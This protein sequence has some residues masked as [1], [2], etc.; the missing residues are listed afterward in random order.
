MTVSRAIILAAGQGFQLD[1]I[2]KV[3]LRHPTTGKTILQ[4]AIE[5]FNG[6]EITVVVGYK[7]IDIMQDY[8]Q[9]DYVINPDWAASSN[10]LSLGLALDDRP[11]Y[12][13][14]GDIFLS[15]DLIA[16]LDQSAPDLV[17]CEGRENRSLTAVH[18]VFDEA[19]VLEETYHGPVRDHKHPEA[20]GLFK[21]S[22]S[23]LLQRW[24]KQ[25]L[26]HSNLFVGETLPFDSAPIHR[27]D[28]GEHA[29]DEI[30]THVDYLN[31]LQRCR[32][33]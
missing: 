24:K 28:L 26:K 33:P 4:T 14:S 15:R 29:F 6:K 12:V 11:A 27:H 25:C 22:S 7:A 18:C 8:P 16:E 2:C 10:A 17:L 9:L 23:A 30:N 32:E 20:I 19:G 3:L 13:V 21:A 5:A 1:G 31:L